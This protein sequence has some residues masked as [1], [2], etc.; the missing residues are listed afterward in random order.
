MGVPK[1]PV[2]IFKCQENLI[3]VPLSIL[4]QESPVINK[5]FAKFLDTPQP[6]ENGD[7]NNTGEKCDKETVVQLP[8]VDLNHYTTTT[9]HPV[10]ILFDY[11]EGCTLSLESC[12][13]MQHLEIMIKLCQEFQITRPIPVIVARMKRS[14]GFNLTMSNV[15]ETF[16]VAGRLSKQDEFKEV[17]EE[18]V[19]RC[20]ML[21][22][23]NL[24]SR[25]AVLEF[26]LQNR[27]VV[28][29]CV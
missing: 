7:Q 26:L 18:L 24:T 12:S 2:I 6:E 9:S 15:V 10:K 16:E 21:A 5:R 25:R 23:F 8:V 1:E 29:V 27:C 22:R 14:S 3:T 13:S 17:G 4:C 11:L 19:E 28:Y 20:V